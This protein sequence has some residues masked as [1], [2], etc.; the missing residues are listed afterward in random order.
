MITEKVIEKSKSKN[1]KNT[2]W[3]FNNSSKT[4]VCDPLSWCREFRWCRKAELSEEPGH[5]AQFTSFGVAS[6]IFAP[7]IATIPHNMQKN[8][9]PERR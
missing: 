8:Y 6:G 7:C 9:L 1:Y 2:V 3:S 5:L 4:L